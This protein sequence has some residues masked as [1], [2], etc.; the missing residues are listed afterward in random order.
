MESD[1]EHPKERQW[2]NEEASF[3]LFASLVH[4]F[5]IS[6]ILKTNQ[7]VKIDHFDISKF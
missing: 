4:F 5:K 2:T 7:S 3:Y 6:I 1:Q